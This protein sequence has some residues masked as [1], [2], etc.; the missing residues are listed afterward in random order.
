MAYGSQHQENKSYDFFQKHNSKLPN[1]HFH[2]GNKKIDI[3][4]EYTY[5]GVRKMKDKYVEFWR[6]KMINSS[7]L[8]FFCKFKNE[9]K[10]NTKWK[11]TYPLFKI[12]Q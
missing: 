4:K 9:Y 12:Q 1:L 5:L 8:S 11:N 3:V 7:K 2:I 10:M 6:Q